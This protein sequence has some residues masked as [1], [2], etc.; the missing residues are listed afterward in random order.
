MILGELL[1]RS[2]RSYV[3]PISVAVIYAGLGDK[4]NALQWLEKAYVERSVGLLTLRVH[5]IFDAL[6]SAPRFQD[7]LRRVGLPP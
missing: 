1:E 7:L 6:R 3:E 4:E 2:G 5:P